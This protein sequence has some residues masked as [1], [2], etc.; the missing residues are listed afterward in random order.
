MTDKKNKSVNIQKIFGRKEITAKSTEACVR[1][2]AA[3]N[4][5]VYQEVGVSK[6]KG[7]RADLVAINMKGEIIFTEV[8]SCWA[9]FASDSKWTS[10]LD[11]CNKMYFCIPEWLYESDKGQFIVDQCKEHKVGLLVLTYKY[12][13]LDSNNKVEP[14]IQVVDGKKE[15]KVWLNNKVSA[16]RRKVA[17]DKRRWL[18]TKLAWRGGLCVANLNPHKG[19]IVLR[20]DYKFDAS[21]DENTFLYTFDAHQ[22]AEY[23]KKFP[24]S[25]YKQRLKD[26]AVQMSIQ[27][28]RNREQLYENIPKSKR[29]FR[30]ATLR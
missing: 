8:K 30:R 5:S 12:T 3:K 27:K 2:F 13:S 21:V 23:L 22:Q 18:I 6:V 28:K 10:Y 20:D 26:P 9:D 17:G 11:Y 7:A 4:F 15:L 24:S 25:S 16:R 29:R 14:T 19:G 1:Y